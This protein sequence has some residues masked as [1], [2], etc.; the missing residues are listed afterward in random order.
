M[1]GDTGKPE[2]LKQLPLDIRELYDTNPKWVESRYRKSFDNERSRTALDK[3]VTAAG[4]SRDGHS[5]R[6]VAEAMGTSYQAARQSLIH[7]RR[8]GIAT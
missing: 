7:A 5:V 1:V 8:F 6:E 4:L 2:W 3:A